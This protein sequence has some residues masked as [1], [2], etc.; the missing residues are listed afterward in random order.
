MREDLASFSESQIYAL[1]NLEIYSTQH[2]V[3]LSSSVLIHFPLISYSVMCY[4]DKYMTTECLLGICIEVKERKHKTLWD[5]NVFIDAMFLFTMIFYFNCLYFSAV[6][7][8][9]A[10]IKYLLFI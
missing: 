6:Q 4:I 10:G 1:C 5:S 7:R 3:S 9:L 2:S 8:Q